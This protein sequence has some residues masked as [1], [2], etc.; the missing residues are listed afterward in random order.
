MTMKPASEKGFPQKIPD[1]ESFWRA[2]YQQAA[3]I[4]KRFGEDHVPGG[5][6]SNESIAFFENLADPRERLSEQTLSFT[7]K[8]G[9]IGYKSSYT[10]RM[11]AVCVDFLRLKSHER[12][13][14]VGAREEG[15]HYR[16]EDF[17]F[18]TKVVDE[19]LRLKALP[20]EDREAER[21]RTMDFLLGR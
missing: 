3:P 18:F 4:L 16:G 10:G 14:V 12:A 15:I 6:G 8:D 13:F 5:I 21:K 11:R 9:S 19:F 20:P 1:P 17:D 7:G 2:W